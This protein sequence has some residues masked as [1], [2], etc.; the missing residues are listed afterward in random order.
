MNP[1]WKILK[2]TGAF[3]LVM[4]VLRA[5]TTPT[6]MGIATSDGQDAAF[7]LLVVFG[8]FAVIIWA[9]GKAI[10]AVRK[11]RRDITLNISGGV[12]GNLNLGKVL[13][14]LNSNIE[15]L[16]THGNNK[17]AE[18]LSEISHCITASNTASEKVKMDLLEK[19][20]FISS[21]ASKE[22]GEQ[23]KSVLKS[24]IES[25]D[26]TLSTISDIAGVWSKGKSI[27]VGLLSLI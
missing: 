2:W 12:V 14:S 3:L 1:M 17:L 11:S 26:S 15:N 23:N 16:E 20:S 21:E 10:G 18:V 4:M 7:V 6:T 24:V 27:L 19:L 8:M 9:T 25:L 5:L 13:G 22:K